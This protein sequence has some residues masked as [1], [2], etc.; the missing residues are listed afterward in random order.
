M[1]SGSHFVFSY[2]GQIDGSS[3]AFV[4]SRRAVQPTPDLEVLVI[5]RHPSPGPSWPDVFYC[6]MIEKVGRSVEFVRWKMCGNNIVEVRK[7]ENIICARV[8]AF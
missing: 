7:N 2:L 5:R 6:K 8:C 3:N 1:R 4:M